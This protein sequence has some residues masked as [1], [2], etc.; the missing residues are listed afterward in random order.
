MLK[1]NEVT[2]L[3]RQTL[4]NIHEFGVYKDDVEKLINYCYQLNKYIDNDYFKEILF[5]LDDKIN[6]TMDEF[7]ILEDIDKIRQFIKVN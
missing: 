4:I 5:D 7:Y 6:T 3:I 2:K 1:R